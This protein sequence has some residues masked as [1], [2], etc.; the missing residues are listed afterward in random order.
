MKIKSNFFTVILLLILFLTDDSDIF[1]LLISAFLHELGHI[2]VSR[3][4]KIDLSEMRIGLFGAGLSCDTSSLSYTHEIFL[5]LGGPITNF[6]TA[7]LGLLLIQ[8]ATA[9]APLGETFVYASLFLGTINLLPIKGFDG[10]RIFY[11][12]FSKLI[13]DKIA[14]TLLSAASF[15]FIFMMWSFSLFF[16]LKYSFSLSMFIFSLSLFVKI[17]MEE[18]F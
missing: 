2:A 18:D 6:L 4:L 10:G 16:L 8:K 14:A 7:P 12:S 17:F 1:I 5:C 15:A 13:S 11:A 9:I 3:M